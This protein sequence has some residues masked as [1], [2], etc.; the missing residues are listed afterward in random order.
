M[1][2]PMIS[3]PVR[4]EHYRVFAAA[5]RL[6]RKEYGAGAPS[7]VALIQFQLANRSAVGVAKDYLDCIGD[8]EGRRRIRFKAVRCVALTTR[9]GVRSGVLR[10]ISDPKDP[11][12]N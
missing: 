12:R 7:A 3:V 8:L 10:A 1:K 9:Y 4:R 2:S 5:V 11:S 6:I